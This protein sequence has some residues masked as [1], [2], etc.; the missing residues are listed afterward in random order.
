MVKRL[1][2]SVYISTFSKQKEMLTNFIGSESFIFTSFHIA[3][4]VDEHYIAKAKEM[5]DWLNQHDFKILA[6]V[7]PKTLELFE[8]ESL[9]AFAS[10]FGLD[11]LRLDYGF[12]TE[13]IKDL[14]SR[15]P[16]MVN[17]STL[18]F[19]DELVSD[20]SCKID[21]MHNF[22]PRPETGLDRE[23]FR[24]INQQITNQNMDVLAFIP[25]DTVMRGPIYEGLPTLEDHRNQPPY[26]SFLDLVK[27]EGI[28]TV[29][30][31]DVALS[32]RQID[33][34][35]AY[36]DT[37]IIQV[38]VELDEPYTYLYG[39]SFTI[40]MDSPSGLKRF[41]ESRQIASL[42]QA[43]PKRRTIDRKRGVLTMD[44]EK[45]L[46]YSGEIQWLSQDYPQDDR[47]NVIGEVDDE[48]L[49]LLDL[50]KNGDVIQLVKAK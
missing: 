14:S 25:G 6:D 43:V 12:N 5:C 38:P 41:Q 32:T 30:V 17:A 31:G 13:T 16:L 42:G 21:A 3:E 24:S 29:C 7:S 1:G 36:L 10:D 9:V 33:L 35:L 27:N 26:V 49:A 50:V 23:L 39:K 4:E 47:V 37:G 28:E 46:R 18:D 11:Q 20:S 19:P 44:N 40:R 2:L 8:Y 22:Y 48:Y 45:Y 15:Y 34:I